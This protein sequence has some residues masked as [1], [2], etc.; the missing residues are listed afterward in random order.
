MHR[1]FG[2]FKISEFERNGSVLSI[3]TSESRRAKVVGHDDI[4]WR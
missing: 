2:Q 3:E 1:Q 4:T